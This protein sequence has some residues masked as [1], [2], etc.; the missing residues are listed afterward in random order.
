MARLILCA[1]LAAGLLGAAE[2]AAAQTAGAA[3]LAIT[4]AGPPEAVAGELL[5]YELQVGMSGRKC[6]GGGAVR[7]GRRIGAM[8]VALGGRAEIGTPHD[9]DRRP[10]F[11][12]RRLEKG[13]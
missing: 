10:A 2:P 5:T 8:P 13:H 4:T 9:G 6:R 1:A 11:P 7:Q 3:G 12:V